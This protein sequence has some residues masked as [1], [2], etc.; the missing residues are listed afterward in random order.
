MSWDLW[1]L[2]NSALFLPPKFRANEEVAQ[3]Q[4]AGDESTSL[5][6]VGGGS[7]SGLDAHAGLFLLHSSIRWPHSS[8]AQY[9][10]TSG[11]PW[12]LRSTDAVCSGRPADLKSMAFPSGQ[13]AHHI[14]C[15]SF[16]GAG[17]QED[18]ERPG[19]FFGWNPSTWKQD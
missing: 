14:T 16:L 2:R 4:A 9:R 1:G 8:N 6:K 10:T 18:G 11:Q 19:A 7:G 13:L 3:S 5:I 17:K 12:K 15:S